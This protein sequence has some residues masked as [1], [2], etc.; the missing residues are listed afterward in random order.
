MTSNFVRLLLLILVVLVSLLH[1]S[2]SPISAECGPCNCGYNNVNSCLNIDC[3]TGKNC[4]SCGTDCYTCCDTGAA[5]PLPTPTTPPGSTP[6]PTTPPGGGGVVPP[7]T[8]VPTT[9]CT[10][11]CNHQVCGDTASPC[12]SNADCGSP[13]T[14]NTSSGR[15]QLCTTPGTQCCGYCVPQGWGCSGSSC[16]SYKSCKAWQ[17]SVLI[18]DMQTGCA[19]ANP[20]A[21]APG[22]TS[23]SC[24]SCFEYCGAGNPGGGSCVSPP[25][26]VTNIQPSGL[27]TPGN[28]A[29]SSAIRWIAWPNNPADCSPAVTA[30]A[31]N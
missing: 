29:V 22:A 8:P 7:L 19:N 2:L 31:A 26:A 28:Y 15:C 1:I 5:Q 16:A 9:A 18:C 27:I 14:C 20:C 17:G 24:D 10:I 4:N 11:S 30:V 3:G 23:S 25:P 12:T 13:Y 21:S 6:A